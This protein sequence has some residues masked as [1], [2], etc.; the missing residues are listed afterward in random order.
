[1]TN[2][3]IE[4]F[5]G[6]ENKESYVN[7]KIVIEEISAGQVI[8]R[9]TIPATIRNLALS[10]GGGPSTTNIYDNARF[11][12]DATGGLVKLNSSLE[13]VNVD[14]PSEMG[15]LGLNFFTSVGATMTEEV[16]NGVKG[17][18]GTGTNSLNFTSVSGNPIT[19][20]FGVSYNF[21]S[22]GR[23]FRATS[24]TFDLF[25]SGGNTMFSVAAGN[26]TRD[27][28]DLNIAEL[29]EAK[30]FILVTK[31][32]NDGTNNTNEIS[33]YNQ[34]NPNGLVITSDTSTYNP[35]NSWSTLTMGAGVT[36]YIA[37][38]NPNVENDF[39][40]IAKTKINF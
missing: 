33:V 23:V 22:S 25:A 32:T 13:V 30:P 1:M 18:R 17:I 9:A 24:P 20:I 31:I 37:A 34:N 39:I 5:D 7:D 27:E 28:L 19:F 40:N 6:V 8:I 35:S 36:H 16:I 2:G 29:S 4:S 26:F 12:M 15:S 38:V 11:V 21:S 10:A 14:L 3:L